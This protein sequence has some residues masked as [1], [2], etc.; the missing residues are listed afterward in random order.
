MQLIV[1]SELS[2]DAGSIVACSEVVLGGAP[3]ASLKHAG[4]AGV[5]CCGC[6]PSSTNEW[7]ENAVP[8]VVV[9][10]SSSSRCRLV[11]RVAAEAFSDLAISER[12]SL[13]KN[14]RPPF[15]FS[16]LS[17]CSIEWFCPEPVLSILY[18]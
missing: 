2:P 3:T 8:D 16:E 18:L 17:R 11:A 12:P 5:H 14:K 13:R 4:A 1:L 10:R 15:N 6:S 9:V 7:L